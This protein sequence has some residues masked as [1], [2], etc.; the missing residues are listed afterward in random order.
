[1]KLNVKYDELEKT[2][3]YITSKNEELKKSFEKLQ[4][5]INK[6]N[7]AWDG[8]D[9]EVFKDKATAIIKEQQEKRQDVEI[10]GE[11]ITIVSNNYKDKDEAWEEKI[12]KENLIDEYNNKE[13]RV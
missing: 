10:L 7:G 3:K 12:K 1:M 2:G 9:Y 4:D 11:I 6:L 8:Q 13:S 5:I